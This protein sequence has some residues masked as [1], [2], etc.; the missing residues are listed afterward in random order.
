MEHYWRD[1]ICA[2]SLNEVSRRISVSKPSIYREFGGEDGLIE[3]VLGHYREA[4]VVPVL[5]HLKTTR[6]FNQIM[7]DL[8]IGMTTERG[9]PPGC[10]FTEMR[11]LRRHLGPKSIAKVELVESERRDAFERWY[12]RALENSE[13]NPALS[14]AAAARFIDAQFSMV[15][16][17]MGMGQAID[18]VRE[19][20]RLAMRT[21]DAP[22]PP[23]L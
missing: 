14:P 12:A 7:E 18:E 3:A 5:D 21:L 11:L 19:H 17:H 10:L 23:H 1:G 15:L 8:I 6:P 16:L 2:L 20:A 13:V 22:N 9:A 4:T